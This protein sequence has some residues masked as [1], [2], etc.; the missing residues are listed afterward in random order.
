MIFVTKNGVRGSS[1]IHERQNKVTS[2]DEKNVTISRI[3]AFID[4]S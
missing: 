3:V 4:E 2:H 1:D